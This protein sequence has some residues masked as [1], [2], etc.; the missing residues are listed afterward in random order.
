MALL[1][2]D[3]RKASVIAIR[4]CECFVLDR[5]TFSRILNSLQHA[6]GKETKNRLEVLKGMYKELVMMIMMLLIIIILILQLS[7]S[8][9]S[10]LYQV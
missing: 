6:I 5:D 10:L 8:F 2:D 4:P 9:S 7:F 3:V 1:D